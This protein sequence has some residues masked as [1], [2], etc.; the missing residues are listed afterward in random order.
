M[1]LSEEHK[2]YL[3]QHHGTRNFEAAVGAIINQML[4][5]GGKRL[6][7]KEHHQHFDLSWARSNLPGNPFH[8]TKQFIDES[9]ATRVIEADNYLNAPFQTVCAWAEEQAKEILEELNAHLSSKIR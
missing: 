7:P 3:K 4:Y 6:L 1:K 2:N 5:H 9:I 8:D